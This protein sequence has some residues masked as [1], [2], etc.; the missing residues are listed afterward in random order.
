MDHAEEENGPNGRMDPKMPIHQ[1]NGVLSS[2]GRAFSSASGMAALVYSGR[3]PVSPF[4]GD[5]SA[6]RPGGKSTGEYSLSDEELQS[7]K[8]ELVKQL[9]ALRIKRDDLQRIPIR[10]HLDEWS[11]RFEA[12]KQSYDQTL[13]TLESATAKR[14]WIEEQSQYLSKIQVLGETSLIWYKGP[15]GT[16][17]GFRL[18]RSA[19]TV[20]GLLARQRN[21][22]K[23]ATSGARQQQQQ[24]QS[25][26]NGDSFFGQ[27]APSD[28]AANVNSSTQQT[29]GQ[30][31]SNL[32][33]I[34]TVPWTEINSALGQIVFMLSTV[35]NLSSSG[36][37]FGKHVLQPTGSSS[38]IG[39]V[40][41]M[42]NQQ[43]NGGHRTERRRITALSAYYNSSP[44]QR[45]APLPGEV[46]WYNLHH[47]E[48]SGSIL[49]MGYYAR[50]NFNVALDALL[51]C[52]AEACL[53]MQDRDM[54]LAAPYVMRVGGLVVGK[55]AKV[56]RGRGDVSGDATL[57]GLP[58]SYD[59]AHGERW[60]LV[61]KHLL[62]NLK[63]LLAYFA[64]WEPSSEKDKI[65][66]EN[67]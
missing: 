58:F 66:I 29:S 63:W 2:V 47:Y 38:K 25:G 39:I 41:N 15:F 65:Q 19:V 43:A 42:Q 31:Q 27:W 52:V 28:A 48:E 37:S 5:C 16:I 61:C 51:Y 22:D 13:S 57:G 32:T 56:A 10:Q 24:Q 12:A 33:E 20:A 7:V 11:Y 44:G 17:N 53:V 62:T 54:A 18:G 55:D 1:Q 49:S 64:R 6:A 14:I 4:N 26:R 34:V 8:D 40:K 9:E 23:A 45:S 59:P 30:N 67:G 46:T 60:T 35:Q 36:I 50:R 3:R 21:N